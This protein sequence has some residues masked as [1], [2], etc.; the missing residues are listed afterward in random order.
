M[1]DDTKVYLTAHGMVQAFVKNGVKQPAVRVGESN[2]QQVYNVTIKLDDQKDASGKPIYVELAFWSGDWGNAPAGIEEGFWCN[3]DG[4]YRAEGEQGQF[5]KIT[6]MRA[7]VV[8]CMKRLPRENVN[9][10]PAQTGGFP[11]A[12]AP[13]AQHP[14]VPVQAQAAA[15]DPA[16]QAFLQQQANA[17]A[18]AAPAMAVVN[19]GAPNPFGGTQGF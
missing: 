13:V 4:Q 17:A 8:P 11:G 3:V 14:G 10:A 12:P 7:V 18:Q 19:A 16:Y 1:S 15:V 6:P 9:Q 5:H 2:G